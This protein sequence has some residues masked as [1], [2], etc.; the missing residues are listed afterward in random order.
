MGQGAGSPTSGPARGVRRLAAIAIWLALWQLASLA[1]GSELLLPGPART[2]AALGGVIR[3]SRFMPIVGLTALRIALGFLLGFSLAVVLGT[4]SHVSRAMREL[5]APAVSTLKSVPVVCIIVLLLIW[6]GATSVSGIVVFLAIFPA[7]Y[8]SVVEGLENADAKLARMLERLCVSRPRR[9]LALGWPEALPYVR[10]AS[11]NACGMAWKA[12]IAAEV[13]GTPAGSVGERIYQA[14]LLLETSDVFAWTIIVVLA[15]FLCERAF[16]AVLGLTEPL[17]L[18]ASV[19]GLGRR[20]ARG[21]AATLR[22]GRIEL[23][24]VTIG[25]GAVAVV[26]HV[27]LRLGDG[28]RML[29]GDASGAGKTTLLRTILGELSPLAG[30]MRVCERISAVWQEV[31]LI[32]GLGAIDNVL[33]VAGATIERDEARTLLS[34]LLPAD[35]L[36]QPVRRL[37]GG[38]RR[39]VELA[40]ALACHSE[41]V[42]LDEPFAS[43]DADSHRMAAGFVLRHLGGRPLLV[44]SHL[45]DDVE[46]LDAE[47]LSL[48]SP[49]APQDA[50]TLS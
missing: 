14:K 29:L 43:L 17:S 11:K 16:L 30:R 1:I 19:M 44:A 21:T 36:D 39:R 48:V 2:L 20:R 7:L 13:V 27:S 25:Y 41:A 45:P 9:L 32:E 26:E 46:L 42:L 50:P 6:V 15:A 37:S 8:F 49:A 34:E 5:V 35:V 24:D 10:A 12:G 40:R 18:R 31:R 47:T 23:D 38:Q 3:S 28:S 33:L 22:G 4:I